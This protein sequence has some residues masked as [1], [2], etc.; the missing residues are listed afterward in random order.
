[1][2]SDPLLKTLCQLELALH[3]PHVR[4]CRELLVTYLHPAFREFAGSGEVFTRAVVLQE[5]EARPMDFEVWSQDFRVEVMAEGCALL[6][7]RT[8]HVG[9]QGRLER[10][11]V[12]ASVWQRVDGQWQVRFHQGT[13]APP[14]TRDEC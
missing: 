12:R 1:M 8:A 9:E 11:T 10:H 14:F 3:Q 2:T 5:F 4:K 6:T 13:P 7:Y